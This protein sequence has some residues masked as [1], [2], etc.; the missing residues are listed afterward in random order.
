[1]SLE[2]VAISLVGLSLALSA[3]TLLIAWELLESTHRSERAGEE[4]LEVLREQ[5]E[6]LKFM[7]E[8]RRLLL[9]ELERQRSAGN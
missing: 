2:W 7:D 8:E 4:R 3:A 9:E 5:Q 6:R 1:M